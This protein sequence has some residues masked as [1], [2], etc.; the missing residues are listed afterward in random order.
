LAKT[1]SVDNETYTE[2]VS[3]TGSLMQKAG[4]QISV[5]NTTRIAIAYLES[6]LVH[7]PRLEEAILDLISF[8]E[9]KMKYASI[10]EVTSKWFD[11]D[12]LEVAFGIKQISDFNDS[13]D[14]ISELRKKGI[15][16]IFGFHDAETY[17]AELTDDSKVK[18]LRNGEEYTS[19][20]AAASAIRGY[21]ENGWRFWKYLDKD[22]Y[23]PLKTLRDVN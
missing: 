23:R 5:S 8:E 22:E 16:K 12:F 2:L 6:C 7:F 3:L 13:A 10:Q 18:I 9:P 4:E 20:S 19:L 14:S 1:I 17:E 15:T 11:K 21:P